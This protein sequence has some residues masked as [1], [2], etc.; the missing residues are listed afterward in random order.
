MAALAGLEPDATFTLF[1]RD[2]K[3]GAALPRELASFLASA[4]AQAPV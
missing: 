4:K 1:E 3:P 2:I